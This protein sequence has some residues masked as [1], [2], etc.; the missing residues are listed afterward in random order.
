MTTTA[1]RRTLFNRIGGYLSRSANAGGPTPPT[2]TD[3]QRS[4]LV[5]CGMAH[6][7]SDD[8][9]RRFAAG[10]D[11]FARAELEQLGDQGS[12]QTGEPTVQTEVVRAEPIEPQSTIVPTTAELQPIQRNDVDIQ[13]EIDAGIQRALEQRDTANASRLEF[14]R[15]LD[16]DDIPRE[17]VQRAQTE[18]WDTARIAREFRN[19]ARTQ[20]PDA[21][22]RGPGI[23]VTGAEQRNTRQALQA[24]LLLRE[25]ISLDDPFLRT[26]QAAAVLRRP[27]NDAGWLH[28]LN[29]S[30]FVGADD[31][32]QRD[33]FLRA[34]DTAHRFAEMPLV[35]F[36]RMAL[37]IERK[38]IPWGQEEIVRTALSTATL[39]AVFSTSINMQILAA[40]MAKPDTTQ[41]WTY[42]TD[43]NGFQQ[44]QRGRMTKGSGMA[45][46]KKGGTPQPITFSDVTENYAAERYAGRFVID[47]QDIIDNTLGGIQE[48]TTRELGELARE[49]KINLVYA[50]LLSNPNM[51]DGNPLFDATHGNTGTGLGWG[52]TSY[53]TVRAAM[54]TQTENARNI[55]LSLRHVIAPELLEFEVNQLLTSAENRGASGETGTS[56]PARGTAS[57]HFDARLDNGVTNPATDVFHAGSSSTWFGAT[58]GGRAGIEIGWRRGTGRAPRMESGV[59][60]TSEGYG[61]VYRVNVDLGV[62]AVDWR[63]LYRAQ[64]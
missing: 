57:S 27:Q 1:K 42:E 36:C 22:S 33:A 60:P 49:I 46:L 64:A 63:G 9:V 34:T 20:R 24:G 4:Y 44:Q 14:I 40:Y 43:V 38:S 59:L 50:V 53:K 7:A 3:Q 37:Q 23:H 31:D 58:A 8:T 6:D 28:D 35:D 62:K 39:S 26:S 29:R 61:I 45:K 12:P 18:A 48:H 16:G 2:F 32:S 5:D 21:I 56:N 15:E 54:A 17:L 47:E 10:L 55:D 13:A 51:R 52:L 11:D 30:G 19:A 25:G 41:G